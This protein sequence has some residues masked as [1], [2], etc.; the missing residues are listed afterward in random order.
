MVSDDFGITRILRLRIAYQTM[1]DYWKTTTIFTFLFSG[2]A[3]MYALMYPT[4]RETMESLAPSMVEQFAWIPGAEDMSSYVGFLNIEMYQI[5]WVLF[6]G[7][8]LGFIGASSVSK[9]IESKTI[10]LLMSN[11]VSRKQIIFEKFIG[12][13]PM[14]IIV[15]IGVILTLVLVTTAINE[16]MN[17]YYLFLTHLVSIPYFL[18]VLGIGLLVS[19]VINEKMKASVITIA[20]VISMFLFESLSQISLDYESL[21]LISLKHYYNPYNTLKFGNIDGTGVIVLLVVTIWTLIFA[22]IYFEHKDI[23]I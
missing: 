8:I 14:V 5:F 21:G 2:I 19:T 12:I 16:E 1:K 7:M 22:M 9:E 11:P 3:V 20:I 10:D 13:V 6:L 18:A 15:N 17:F 23:K 4:F